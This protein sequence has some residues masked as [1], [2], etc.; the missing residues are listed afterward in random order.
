MTTLI[1]VSVLV[2]AYIWVQTRWQWFVHIGG[3][4]LTHCGVRCDTQSF[5]WNALDLSANKATVLYLYESVPGIIILV[6]RLI[7]MLWYFWVFYH[8]MS[9]LDGASDQAV[10]HV[11]LHTAACLHP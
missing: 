1:L 3:R 7:I 11:P 8:R 9:K 2:S 5:L 4:Q 6:C 10:S